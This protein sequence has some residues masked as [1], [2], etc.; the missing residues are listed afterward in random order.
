MERRIRD[1]IYS[2]EIIKTPCLCLITGKAF[3]RYLVLRHSCRY[4]TKAGCGL[5]FAVRLKRDRL[6]IADL[7]PI[8]A[9]DRDIVP[10]LFS[11]SVGKRAEDPFR[12][13]PARVMQNHDRD[14]AV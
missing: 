2:G 12:P 5:C 10:I 8:T 6:G 3:L 14:S 9:E 4:P 13:P 11:P 7:D 1:G